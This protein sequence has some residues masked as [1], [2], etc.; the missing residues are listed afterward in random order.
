M[1][2][3]TAVDG[4]LKGLGQQFNSMIYNIIDASMSVLL[5]WTLMPKIGIYGYVICVFLTELVNLAFS[6]NRLLTVTGVKIPLCRSVLSPVVCII[7]ATSLATLA[8]RLAFP[9]PPSYLAVTV[10]GILLSLLFYLILLRTTQGLTS[11]DTAW[12]KSI[13]KDPKPASPAKKI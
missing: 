7:G 8:I 12:L 9:A 2:L 10:I 4:M 13:L 11:E 5:V 6:L 3:D 1:Y